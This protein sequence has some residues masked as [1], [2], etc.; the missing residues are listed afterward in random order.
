MEALREAWPNVLAT[1]D[2]DGWSPLHS[3][4][5]WAS[6]DVVA[7]VLEHRPDDAAVPNRNVE[8]PIHDAVFKRRLSSVVA[9]LLRARPGA[10]HTRN[11][12]GDAALDVFAAEWARDVRGRVLNKTTRQEGGLL[13]RVGDKGL[14]E[15]GRDMNDVETD[16]ADAVD[17]FRGTPSLLLRATTTT[18]SHEN[19][20]E[21]WSPLLEA[22]RCNELPD[23]V[24]WLFARTTKNQSKAARKDRG[25]NFPLHLACA[26][27]PSYDDEDRE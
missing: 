19:E 2:A 5:L 8:L 20:D 10:A 27:R 14:E 4:C 1:H 15:L 22:T 13:D 9:R 7:F 11:E 25:G 24:V 26:R 23:P 12:N 18:M 21:D 3:A 17:V 16:D 6:E